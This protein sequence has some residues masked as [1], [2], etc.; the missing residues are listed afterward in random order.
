M[1]I[2]APPKIAD[3]KD[4]LYTHRGT[5][6]TFPKC[7][8]EGYPEPIVTWKRGYGMMS[9]KSAQKKGLLTIP[10][11]RIYDEGFYICTAKNNLGTQLF[12]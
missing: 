4:L 1:I 11:V 12:L 6:F 8:V 3:I 9:P 10:S 7:E 5:R 2:L